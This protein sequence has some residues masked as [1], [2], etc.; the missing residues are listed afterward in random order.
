MHDWMRCT[1]LLVTR[2]RCNM[3]FIPHCTTCILSSLL[4]M[5]ANLS[6]FPPFFPYLSLFHPYS[7]FLSIPLI[8]P[9]ILK[10]HY[11]ES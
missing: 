8:L 11:P 9:I 10:E 4:L 7:L 1:A 2:D 3:P 5:S 6:V